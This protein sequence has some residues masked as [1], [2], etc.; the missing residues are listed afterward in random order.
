MPTKYLSPQRT[1]V[2]RPVAGAAVLAL[3]L[4]FAACGSET[5]A[6]LQETEVTADNQVEIYE[7]I[8]TESHLTG[9]ELDLL[10]AYLQRQNLPQGQYLPT[11][12]TVAEMIQE[13][14]GFEQGVQ[15]AESDPEAVPLEENA[16][17]QSTP[18]TETASRRPAPSRS[19]GAAPP[20]PPVGTPPAAQERPAEDTAGATEPERSEAREPEVQQPAAP[21]SAVVPAGEEIRVRLEQSIGSKRNNPGDHFDASL[22]RDLVIGGRLLAPEGS[23]VVGRIT[24]AKASGRIKGRARLSITLN[25]LIVEGESYPLDTN[26]L[27][28]EADPSKKE[29]AKKIG[30]GAGA[31][32]IIGAI[33][34]GGKGAAIGSAI[35]AGAGTGAVLVTSGKEVEFGVEQ[36]FEFKLREEVRLKIVR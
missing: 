34:G 17:E 14:R 19:S 27:A 18:G 20:E 12:K 35:G 25:R 8:R 23:R 16:G 15:V 30:I 13:Q 6:S 10:Q 21:T 32:A 24:D 9:E 31:G 1:K 3:L 2:L 22:D 11:G 36:P 28:F 5:A 29:D 4:L 7:K 26:V 33:A